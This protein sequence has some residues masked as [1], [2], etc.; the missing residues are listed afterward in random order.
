M[1]RAELPL[2]MLVEIGE[3]FCAQHPQTHGRSCP[4]IYSEGLVLA[5]WALG[6]LHDLILVQVGGHSRQILPEVPERAPCTT[7][8]DS[9][10]RRG[11]RSSTGG[12]PSEPWAG[13]L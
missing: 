6:Q 9:Y 10:C 3:A 12:W 4:P 1:G 11:G 5:L 13:S 2:A 8:C 7:G